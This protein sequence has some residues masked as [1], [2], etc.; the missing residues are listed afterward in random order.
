M[1][2]TNNNALSGHRG[3]Y[4]ACCV[5]AVL[6]VLVAAS[7]C[8]AQNLLVNGDF[9]DGSG[10]QPTAWRTE[11]WIPRETTTFSWIPPFGGIPGE[12]EISNL[13]LNDARW[14]QSTTLSP[15][16]Y[17][18][19]VEILTTGVPPQTWAGGLISIGDQGVA[20]LDVKGNT[21]WNRR[22]VFFVTHERT[23]IEVKLR[24]GGF[25]NF[26]VGQAF[27]RNAILDRIDHAP[28]GALV[29]DLD[30]DK[31]LW[32][33]SHWTLV[34]LWLLLVTALLIGWHTLGH[35]TKSG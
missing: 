35:P 28:E 10:N 30:A 11:A 12:V 2:V 33:G 8:A 31:R 24:L 21:T 1:D 18:A 5:A 22:E 4:L 19:S 14:V 34:P 26:A 27:F 17:C 13:Q 9:S 29:L 15:G 3:T 23:K 6:S 32:A 20:S 25:L 7:V 16:L